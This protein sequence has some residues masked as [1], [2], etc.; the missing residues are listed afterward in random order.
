MNLAAELE[1][2]ARL[3]AQKA[4]TDAEFAKAKSQLLSGRPFPAFAFRGIRRQSSRTVFGRPL[5][6][7]AFGP[8]WEQGE[9]RGHARGIFAFGDIATGWVA[10]GGLA[11][12]V[13]AFG[14]LAV[15]VF[16]FGGA[17]IGALLAIGGG[18]IGGIAAGGG[19]IG[20]VAVGGGAFGYFALGGGA[21]GVHVVSALRQDPEA[22]A[23]FR[24][25][26]PRIAEYL[27]R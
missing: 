5:W 26:L 10:C 7:I 21:E 13:F 11:R 24:E 3:H 25:Y 15:G 14:G 27:P 4:L 8:D 2:L 6:A 19:A 23:F 22:V 1:R 20:L 17:A 9:M 12:G 18:A 16:A